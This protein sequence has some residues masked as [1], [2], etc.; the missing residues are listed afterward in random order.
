MGSG[1]DETVS[2]FYRTERAGAVR[3]PDGG[4]PFGF[5]I[6]VALT[7]ATPRA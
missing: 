5:D 4:G 3:L 7:A 1:L 6:G 2:V